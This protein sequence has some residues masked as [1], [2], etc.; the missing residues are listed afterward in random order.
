VWRMRDRLGA[1]D[2]GLFLAFPAVGPNYPRL[3]SHADIIAQAERAANQASDSPEHWLLLGQLLTSYGAAASRRD[4]HTQE[5][6]ALDRAVALDSSFSTALG[7]RLY[8]AMSVRDQPTIARLAGL[9]ESRVATGFTDD[10]LLWAA[11]RSRGDSTAALRW[12]DRS[13]GLSRTDLMQKL[14]KISLFGVQLGLP[15]ADA[16]WAADKLRR[17]AA[18]ES[19][20]GGALLAHL[21]VRFA[22][23]RTDLGDVNAPYGPGWAASIGQQAL[24]EAAYRPVATA[25]LVAEGRGAYSLS[26]P[27]GG[28]MRWPPVQLCLGTLLRSTA[29]DT[30]GTGA[31]IAGLR[32]FAALEPPPIARSDWEQIEMRVCPLLLDVLRERTPNA[33]TPWPHLD[34]L[35]SL[36]QHG[37][38]ALFGLAGT[39][40]TAFANFTIARLR[41]AHGELPAA[42]A[43]IRRRETDGFPSYLWSRAAFLRQEGRLA[44]LVGDTTGATRA[45]DEY[46]VLR[47]N[48]DAA[49][50]AQRDSVVAERTAIGVRRTP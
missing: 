4:W 10:F 37:P 44:A 8:A 43:A 16:R 14:V 7:A 22:E 49:M 9:L 31:A 15:L 34:A 5:V 48:P 25:I 41:E 39:S 20:R 33:A 27:G 32:Q 2:V 46:L 21:A 50:R 26:P 3:S 45:Y 19:E 1:R 42:L 30:T 38:R 40:P 28:A 12:R 29:G 17:D 36:L 18:T 24:F 23:G 11:A 13:L 47:T 6:D 35:D